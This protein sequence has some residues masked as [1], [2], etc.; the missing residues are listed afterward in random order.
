M[1]PAPVP[2]REPGFFYDGTGL[3]PYGMTTV[4]V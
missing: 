1:L 3:A 4:E 2:A